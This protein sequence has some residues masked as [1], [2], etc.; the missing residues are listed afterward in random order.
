MPDRI[1]EKPD[2]S[3]SGGQGVCEECGRL[4]WLFH[5]LCGYCWDSD[6]KYDD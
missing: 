3:P 2:T 4:E 5:G 6:L 1:I